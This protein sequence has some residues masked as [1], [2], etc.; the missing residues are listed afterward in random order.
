MTR[1][2]VL[3]AGISLL[4]ASTPWIVVRIAAARA[5]R[6]A[7]SRA[8]V[9]GR[10]AGRRLGVATAVV[11][12]P[13]VGLALSVTPP[14]LVLG[15]A[16]LGAFAVLAAFGHIAL[17]AIDRD[18]RAAREVDATER[19]AS[20]RP[21]DLGAYVPFGR[22]LLPY[23]V[24]AAGSAVFVLRWL[25]PVANRRV[26]VPLTFLAAAWVFAALY[27][28][29]MREEVS[30]GQA[31]GGQ[32]PARIERRLRA[33]QI[34]QLVLVAGQAI[35]ACIVVGFDWTRNADAAMA[36]ALVGGVLGVLGCAYALSSGFTGRRYRSAESQR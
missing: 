10:A 24:A 23:V 11:S 8:G 35:G 26:F 15:I 13:L 16:A 4:A 20:L 34:A 31:E 3:Q 33:I 7:G 14:S 25:Q 29:W 27:D 30:G 12:L 9:P 36:V 5:Q 2:Q 21:R 6:D 18:T 1:A 19:V 32:D 28:A 22:R 17:S